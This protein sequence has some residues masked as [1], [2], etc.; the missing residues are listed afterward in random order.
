M[1]ILFDGHQLGRHQTGNET[2]VR[3]LLRGLASRQSIEVVAAVDRGVDLAGLTTGRIDR[4]P[5]P[6]QPLLRLPALALASR[7]LRVDLLHSIYY[8]PPL[9]RRPVLVSIHDVSYERFPQFFSRRELYKN[10]LVVAWAARHADVVLALTEHAKAELIDVYHIDADRIRV[11]PAGV[12]EAFLRSHAERGPGLREGGALQILAVGTVQP[13]KNLLRLV[14][15]LRQVARTREVKLRV[16]GPEGHAAASIRASLRDSAVAVETL[17][18]VT[19][20]ALVQAYVDADVFVYPSIYEGF[21]IPVL[22]AMACG[23]PVVTSTGGAL[24]EV[25]G[26]AALIVDPYDVEG[27]VAAI[28]QAADDQ[29]LRERLS[30]LGRER[31]QRYSWSS[32]VDRLVDAYGYAMGGI[33]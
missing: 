25:A 32:A 33:A 15:A 23:T 16:I 4:E 17:G 8:L 2:Y 24:P 18:Y 27:L 26:Q 7:R 19:E 11:V 12:G 5:L 14:E 22:E 1:R 30:G 28:I 10:R 29:S 3:E 20:Q 13:R 9:A 6:R 21:G 31:A